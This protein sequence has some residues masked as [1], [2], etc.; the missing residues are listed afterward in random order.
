VTN[1]MALC[2]SFF[3]FTYVSWL[4]SILR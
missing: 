4:C 2:E 3:T 1:N